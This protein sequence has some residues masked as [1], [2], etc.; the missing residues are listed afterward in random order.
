[1]GFFSNFFGGRKTAKMEGEYLRQCGLPS[2]EARRSLERQ[3]ERLQISRPGK[4]R[5]WYVEKILYDLQRD[6]GRS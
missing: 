4:N 2:A 5:L 3:I 6:R 1:M